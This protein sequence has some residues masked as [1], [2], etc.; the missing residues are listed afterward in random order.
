[1]TSRGRIWLN[2]GAG[3]SKRASPDDPRLEP[4][5]LP[6]VGMMMLRSTSVPQIGC[7]RLRFA[8]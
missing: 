4:L 7:D 3:L 5:E 6:S 1:M 2:V 8:P